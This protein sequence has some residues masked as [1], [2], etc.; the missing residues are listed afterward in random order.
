M[1]DQGYS[2]LVATGLIVAAA[3]LTLPLVVAFVRDI[4]GKADIVLLGLL[5]GWTGVAW[6]CALFLSVTR[7]RRHRATM[8]RVSRPLSPIRYG[9]AYREGA[10]LVSAGQESRTWAVHADGE[11]RI[12]YEVG[13]V[14][15]LVGPVAEGDVPLGVLAEALRAAS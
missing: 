9:H 12:V 8:P 11:W 6:A 7:P 3:L 14:D 4:D 5:L 15:R 13:G 10:Y 1:T 2:T